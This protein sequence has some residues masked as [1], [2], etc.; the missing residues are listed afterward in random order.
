MYERIFEKLPDY[1]HF[2]VTWIS[3]IS[4]VVVTALAF[5]PTLNAL[6]QSNPWKVAVLLQVFFLVSRGLFNFLMLAVCDRCEMNLPDMPIPML[7]YLALVGMVI[8]GAII[9]T[10]LV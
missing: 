5:W 3:T 10:W 2:R 6:L 4:V 7:V 8:P 1:R 9:A